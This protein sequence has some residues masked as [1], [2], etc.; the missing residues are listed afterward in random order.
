MGMLKFIFG[1]LLA[2]GSFV[3]G[4]VMFIGVGITGG[5]LW[6]AILVVVA[7]VAMFLAGIYIMRKA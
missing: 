6:Q 7:A 4:F 3:F 5:E 1:G 2:F